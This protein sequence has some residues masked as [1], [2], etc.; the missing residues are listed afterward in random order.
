MRDR[1][2]PISYV[3]AAGALGTPHLLLAS[4]LDAL[5]PAATASAAT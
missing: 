4:K 3:I 1:R 2:S 5:S